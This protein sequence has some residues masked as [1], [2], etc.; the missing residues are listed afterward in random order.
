MPAFDTS[1]YLRRIGVDG[2][3]SPGLRDLERIHRGQAYAIPFENFDILLGRPIDIGPEAVFDK[4]V[5]R[6][7]GGYCFE[8]NQL[9]HQALLAFGFEVRWMLARVH[10]GPVPSGLVHVLMIVN[11][12]GEEWLADVGFGASG[13]R[14]PARFAPGREFEQDGLRFRLVATPPF[15]TMLEGAEGPGW[16]PL[17]SFDARPVLPVDLVLGNHYTSTHPASFFTWARVATLPDP[18]GRTS[19][20]DRQLT[21]ERDGTTTRE[22][23]ADGDGFVAMLQQR[24]GIE[25]DAPYASI[26]V[27]NPRPTTAA[28]S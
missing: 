20:F 25:L 18:R 16:R 28:P 23:V 12:D 3:I 5:R 6:R 22:T 2:P 14:A 15:G 19:L 1:A 10:L 13:L 21:I 27:R 24:F 17:F 4:L 7:R 8:L 26:G 11:V 9:L